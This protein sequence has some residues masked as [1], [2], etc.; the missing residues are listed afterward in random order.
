[1]GAMGLAYLLIGMLAS[2]GVEDN[3][4]YYLMGRKLSFFPLTLTILATQ[5]GGGTLVGS[6]Q[7]AY[8][9]GWVVLF[10]PA[11][12]CL[13]LLALG[14]GFGARLRSLNVFTMAEI[15]EKIYGVRAQRYVASALSIIGLFFILVG[16]AIAAKKF[17]IA[18]GI[19]SPSAFFIFW[20]VLVAYTVMG[21]LKAVVNTD[22]LQV[23]FILSVLALTFFSLDMSLVS[24]VSLVP[25][26]D[27]EV[28]TSDVPWTLWLFMPF[29]FMLIEQ[30]M[31]QR[32]FAAKNPQTVSLSALAAGALLL[33]SS[34]VAIYLGVLGRSSGIQVSEES[35]ILIETVKALTTPTVATFFIAA[36]LMTVISTADSLLCSISSN[37][38]CDFLPSGGIKSIRCMTL[39]TG[40]CA[41]AVASFFDNVVAMLMLSYELSVCVLFVP[42]F[43]AVVF[44]D[45]SAKGAWGAMLMGAIGFVFFHL[46]S[47]PVPGEVITVVLSALGYLLGSL[48]K[49]D[50]GSVAP[51]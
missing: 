18:L 14:M 23:L 29:L 31:G 34:S 19:L 45:P 50:K 12:V 42:I 49:G 33:L 20:A 17:F 30:D 37:L 46:W 7:E 41:L 32:C 22:I 16:Q 40:L 24:P 2:E 27:S 43:A 35:S 8:M 44:K 3:D 51:C 25:L 36:V 11:G 21:G 9:K 15:F 28:V 4:D 47:F 26:A 1:M 38:S 6:A 5:L 39:V 48:S 13:G 10:Y